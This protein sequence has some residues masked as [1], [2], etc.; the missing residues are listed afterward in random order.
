VMSSS[1]LTSGAGSLKTTTPAMPHMEG[2]LSARAS[3]EDPKNIG[4][5]LRQCVQ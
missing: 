4:R 2:S 1:E 3:Q 5:N